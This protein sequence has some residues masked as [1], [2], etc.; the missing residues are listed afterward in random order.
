MLDPALAN[1]K[2]DLDQS[3]FVEL[4]NHFV[5]WQH[6]M[7]SHRI[8]DH[9]CRE[10]L[11]RAYCLSQDARR[12]SVP[13]DFPLVQASTLIQAC[14]NHY[15]RSYGDIQSQVTLVTT[16]GQPTGPARP[17]PVAPEADKSM[18]AHPPVALA[19][20]SSSQGAAQKSRP[21]KGTAVKRSVPKD[22]DTPAPMNLS[23]GA[24][25][26]P[27]PEDGYTTD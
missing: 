2:L 26:H 5:V 18:L 23:K 19:M 11:L 6:T 12:G 16:D 13:T 14:L 17:V 9:P 3:E 20:P 1:R 7:E 8:L 22:S 25:V 27:N 15:T 21:R 4:L 24:K 10:G